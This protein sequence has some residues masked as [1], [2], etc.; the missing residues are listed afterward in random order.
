MS[1]KLDIPFTVMGTG[2]EQEEHLIVKTDSLRIKD[3][4]V[5]KI[6]GLFFVTLSY[7]FENIKVLKKAEHIEYKVD[8]NKKGL[9]YINKSKS[10][11][12]YSLSLK[13]TASY[14]ALEDFSIEDFEEDDFT[15]QAGVPVKVLED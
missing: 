9:R 14:A 2:K 7:E 12:W 5:D 4:K 10:N 8:S 11:L 1:F 6:R 13:K 15:F 3:I